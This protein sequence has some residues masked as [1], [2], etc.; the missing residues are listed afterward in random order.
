MASL[1]AGTTGRSSTGDSPFENNVGSESVVSTYRDSIREGAAE[2]AE[3]GVRGRGRLG[4][5][6]AAGVVHGGA[7]RGSAGARG[8]LSAEHCRRP[9]RCRCRAAARP[10]R[11][12]TDTSYAP[13]APIQAARC[14]SRVYSEM[15]GD[16]LRVASLRNATNGQHLCGATLLTQEFASTAAHC[17]HGTG[18]MIQLNNF[19]GDPPNATV[20]EVF[21]HERYDKYSRAHDIALL[22]VERLDLPGLN[23]NVLPEHSFGAGGECMVYGYGVKDVSANELSQALLAANVRIVPLDECTQS[24]GSYMV[25]DFDSGMLCAVGNGVDTCE[26]DSGG[27]LMCY[28]L[29]EGVSSHGL[30]CAAPGVPAVYTSVRAHLAWIQRVIGTRTQEDTFTT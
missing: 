24:L 16:Q 6:G 23:E 2:S 14:K 25:P 20:L 9:V 8:R 26:G 4:R 12:A 21:T 7:R 28:G 17:V 5:R 29:V 13:R 18:Y 10:P 15:I 30:G 27:P 22:R 11:A 1:G 19:C 3:A